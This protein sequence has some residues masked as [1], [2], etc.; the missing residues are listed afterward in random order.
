[1]HQILFDSF[2][3]PT[4]FREQNILSRRNSRVNR[5]LSRKKKIASLLSPASLRNALTGL[6][7]VWFKEQLIDG[8]IIGQLKSSHLL[9]CL[10]LSLSFAEVGHW[11]SGASLGGVGLCIGGESR[12]PQNRFLV[13][14]CLLLCAPLVYLSPLESLQVSS[15]DK[16]P[17][18]WPRR[19]PFLWAPLFS[20]ALEEFSLLWSSSKN[21]VVFYS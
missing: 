1:M 14:S 4:K 9:P 11:A 15:T 12:T 21:R 8:G 2:Y 18:P 19:S 7:S 3:C 20:K 16:W 5:R 17:W 13:S 10:L 6:V